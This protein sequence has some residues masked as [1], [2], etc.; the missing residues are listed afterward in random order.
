V[1]DEDALHA[2]VE[3]AIREAAGPLL[4]HVQ[5]FDVYRGRSIPENRKSLAFSLRYRARDRTLEEEEVGAVH[6][7][8]EQALRTRFRAEVRGR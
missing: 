3:A 1:V 4:E 8:V 7:G 6:A 5:L 2:D